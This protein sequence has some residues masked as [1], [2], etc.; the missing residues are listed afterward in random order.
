MNWATIS[1]IYRGI[2]AFCPRGQTFLFIKDLKN[3]ATAY[4]LN[5]NDLQHEIPLIIKLLLKQPDPPKCFVEFFSFLYSYIV[6]FE[7]LY[8]LLLVLV[9]LPVTS[10]SCERSFSKMKLIKIFLW[11]SMNNDRLSDLALLSI[12][13]SWA[14]GIDCFVEEFDS[15]HDNRRSKLD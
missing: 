13:I 2:S 15:H 7:C 1:L 10:A 12:E 11:N 4:S 3:Y 9:T 5:A 6:T 8:N 14:E